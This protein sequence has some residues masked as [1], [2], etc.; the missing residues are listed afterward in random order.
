MR[1]TS[2]QCQASTK[3]KNVP[4]EKIFEELR[5][6]AL[7][8]NRAIGAKRKFEKSEDKS[9]T[10][11]SSPG[12]S[13]ETIAQ[14]TAFISLMDKQKKIKTECSNCGSEKHVTR[15]CTSSKFGECGKKFKS[16]KGTARQGIKV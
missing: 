16:G 14:V 13:D 10:S 1:W 12:P 8:A 9:T 7:A 11:S 2:V 4:F 6:L 5:H 15:K 3:N